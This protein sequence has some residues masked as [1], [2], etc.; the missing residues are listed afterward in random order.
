MEK[1]KFE[2]VDIEESNENN[3]LIRSGGFDPFD[4]AGCL[5]WSEGVCVDKIFRLFQAQMDDN[6][7]PEGKRFVSFECFIPPITIGRFFI[8]SKTCAVIKRVMTENL[9]RNW[10]LVMRYG[11]KDEWKWA[12]RMSLNDVWASQ[13]SKILSAMSCSQDHGRLKQLLSRV[14][15]PTIQQASRDS[16]VMIEKMADNPLARPMVLNF[17]KTNWERLGRQYEPVFIFS[18]FV[19][20]CI[21]QL[22]IVSFSI[23]S[24]KRS[25]DNLKLLTSASKYLS[26]S[27]EL[28]EVCVC[29]LD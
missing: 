12:W 15:H 13:R 28:N 10:C 14:F 9:E 19:G 20:E 18:K 25:G 17:I 21:N 8:I 6:I 5:Q 29:L 4:S 1:L 7:S 2:R 22:L 26:T 16:F 23:N 11:G 3:N 27:E 24:F